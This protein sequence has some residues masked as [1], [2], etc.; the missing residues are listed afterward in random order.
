MALAT[1]LALVPFMHGCTSGSDAASKNDDVPGTSTE[2]QQQEGS[3]SDVVYYGQVMGVNGDE[4]TVVLGNL[5]DT[6]ND[7]GFRQFVANENEVT[8]NKGDVVIVDEAGA[9]IDDPTVSADQIVVM[10]G[11]GD[12][13]DFRPAKMELLQT[14][15]EGVNAEV[16]EQGLD[17]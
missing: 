12:G 1:A 13:S 9:V 7:N 5:T 3:Q 14:S 6:A 16:A 4:I 8:F 2:Q 15:D 17:Q 10:S 11:S